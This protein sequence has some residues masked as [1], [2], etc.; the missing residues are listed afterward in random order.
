MLKSCI[1]RVHLVYVDLKKCTNNTSC[2]NSPLKVSLYPHIPLFS[3]HILDLFVLASFLRADIIKSARCL[4]A[5]KGGSC[6]ERCTYNE[7]SS[8]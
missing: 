4:P 7:G 2:V 3:V 6:F 8:R 1:T 5:I